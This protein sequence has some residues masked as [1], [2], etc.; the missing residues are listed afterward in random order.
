MVLKGSAYLFKISILSVHRTKV[1]EYLVY[2][3]CPFSAMTASL[4]WL[5]YFSYFKKMEGIFHGD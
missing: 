3:T 4:F 5:V 2:L 1:N